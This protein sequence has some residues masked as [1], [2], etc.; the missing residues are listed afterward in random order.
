MASATNLVFLVTKKEKRG[1]WDHAVRATRLRSSC[2][3]GPTSHRRSVPGHSATAATVFSADVLVEKVV[4]PIAQRP[5]EIV[6]PGCILLTV[7]TLAILNM[8]GRDRGLQFRDGVSAVE[9]DCR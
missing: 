7:S 6:A 4:Q 8:S 3:A 2:S 9:A 1:L 5:G